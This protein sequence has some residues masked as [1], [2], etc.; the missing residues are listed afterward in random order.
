MVS[1]AST[2]FNSLPDL[3]KRETIQGLEPSEEHQ[4]EWEP[5]QSSTQKELFLQKYRGKCVDEVMRAVLD[6]NFG[7]LETYLKQKDAEVNLEAKRVILK[8]KKNTITIAVRGACPLTVAAFIGPKETVELLL[9]RS[10]SETIQNYLEHYLRQDSDYYEGE[11]LF[12]RDYHEIITRHIMENEI[13]TVV[14]YYKELGKIHYLNWM[15]M[16]KVKELWE[17]GCLARKTV[18]KAVHLKI[19]VTVLTDLIMHYVFKDPLIQPLE[20]NS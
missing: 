8:N 4:F 12:N 3:T 11:N 17:K 1:Y 10:N 6:G 7:L 2:P 16:D 15:E 9:A 18:F 5:S 20:C 13:E 19:S 14:T